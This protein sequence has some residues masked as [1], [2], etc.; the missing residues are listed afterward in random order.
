MVYKP[1]GAPVS[2]SVIA[3]QPP[4]AAPRSARFH[5]LA[6]AALCLAPLGGPAGPWRQK[7]KISGR[8]PRSTLLALI[9]RGWSGG[10]ASA[11]PVRGA[12]P[13]LPLTEASAAQQ[14]TFYEHQHR[15]SL[16]LG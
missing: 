8:Q 15:L 12:P 5:R 7:K 3:D 10:A 1:P 6:S 2:D 9:S 11:L 13:R 14:P 16:G 4:L